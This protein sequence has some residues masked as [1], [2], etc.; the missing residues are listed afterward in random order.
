MSTC[1]E[2]QLEGCYVKYNNTSFFGAPDKMEVCRRC[3]P[4]VVYNSDVLNRIDSALAFL[5][6]GNGEYFREGDFG[7]IQG[8][9]QCIQDLSLS[10]CQDCLSEATRRLRSVCETSSWGDMYLGKCY[11]RYADQGTVNLANIGDSTSNESSGGGISV[12]DIIN[13]ISSFS[14]I[15]GTLSVTFVCNKKVHRSIWKVLW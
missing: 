4:S 2:I 3:G 7:S 10:D 14:S 9:A 11:I 12:L 13:T 1:G 15:L 6:G 5:V 8:V